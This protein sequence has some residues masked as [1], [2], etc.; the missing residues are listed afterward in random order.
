M[1]GRPTKKQTG[2][3]GGA[4]S[5]I[6]SVAL[7]LVFAPTT[8]GGSFAYAIVNGN[9]MAPLLT[10]DDMVLLRGA[11]DYQIG[12]AVAYRHPQIGTVLHRIVADDGERFTLSG[13]NRDG[14]DSYQPTR[15]DVIGR[16]WAVIPRGGAV[17]RVLQEPRNLALLIAVTAMLLLGAGAATSRR[18]RP[19]LMTRRYVPQL[20]KNVSIYSLHGRRLAIGAAAVGLGSVVLLSLWQSNGATQ[21]VSEQVP[22]AEQGTFSYGGPVE[23][24]VYDDDTLA[25]PLPLYRQLTN[26]LPLSF[27]YAVATSAT[28]AEITDVLGSY[29]LTAEISTADGW[30]RST[31]LQPTTNFAGDTF[32]TATS[33]DLTALDEELAA[34]AERTGVEAGT[35]SIRVIADVETVGRLAGLPFERSFQPSVQFRLTP[36]QL[37]FDGAEE[38]LLAEATGSVSRDSVAPRTLELPMLPISLTY[39]KLPVTAGLLGLLAVAGFATV[40]VATLITWRGGE[41]ARIRARYATL[42]VDVGAT[43]DQGPAPL[44]VGSFVDLARLATAEGLTVMH[45][46]TATGNEY[47]VTAR[48]THWRYA[49]GQPARTPGG[50][51]ANLITTGDG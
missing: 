48:D 27:V 15:E 44:S 41:V 51:A 14:N 47:F 2:I 26:D 50:F 16:Q 8:I 17:S 42:L 5:L 3:T 29:Q 4:L 11:D 6:L 1:S 45:R 9:S 20:K 23:G 43:A 7:F 38:D 34:I 25:A 24:G 30:K 12:D 32:S 10:T 37:Q 18:R 28:D 49:S 13:D 33:L 46:R 40:G 31:E 21:Q 36:L 19:G 35:Y 39:S 22:F